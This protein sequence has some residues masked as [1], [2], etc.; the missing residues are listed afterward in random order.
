MSFE[1]DIKRLRQSKKM[2]QQEL[3]DILH[4]SRQTVLTWE[5]GKIILVWKF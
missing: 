1:Q 3:A 2:T 5:N 4:V